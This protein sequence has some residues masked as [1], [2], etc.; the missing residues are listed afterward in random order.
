MHLVQATLGH[1]SVAT[2]GRY[3]HARPS[4]SSAR[5]LGDLTLVQSSRPA[6]SDRIERA[7]RLAGFATPAAAAIVLAIPLGTYRNHEAGV[8]TPKPDELR[9]YANTFKVSYR[10][11][12][13]G[14]GQGPEV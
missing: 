6:I 1:A 4:D 13:S 12:L 7:R 14:L 8:H 9:R 3:T 5:Y 10:W 11:L 2:T